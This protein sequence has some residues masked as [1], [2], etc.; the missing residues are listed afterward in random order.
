M[1]RYDNNAVVHHTK[2][3]IIALSDNNL[4]YLSILD[5]HEIYD[6]NIVK[7]YHIYLLLELDNNI[8]Q[9]LHVT[10]ESHSLL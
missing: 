7:D 6:V 9:S 4:P 2:C 10:P 8:I 3:I 5:E 1:G